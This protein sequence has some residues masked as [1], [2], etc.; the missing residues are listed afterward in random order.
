MKLLNL[1]FFILAINASSTYILAQQ[2]LIPYRTDEGK[3]G[4]K[5]LKDEIIVPAIYEE[6][7]PFSEGIGI[8]V[9]LNGYEKY[10]TLYFFNM[11]GKLIKIKYPFTVRCP[12]YDCDHCDYP[13]MKEGIFS[14]GLLP[15]GVPGDIKDSYSNAKWGFMNKEGDLIIKPE[16]DATN[17]FSDGLAPVSIKINKNEE[18]DF[19]VD[20]WF[21][22]F[23]NGKKKDIGEF[24]EAYR[25]SEGLALVSF[26]KNMQKKLGLKNSCAFIDKQGNVKIKGDFTIAFP[27]YEGLAA[28]A[29][30]DSDTIADFGDTIMK[31]GFIDKSGEWVIEPQFVMVL[32]FLNGVA[33]AGIG[34]VTEYIEGE[35]TSVFFTGRIVEI[36]KNGKILGTI[37]ESKGNEDDDDFDG[38]CI[39][40]I[41]EIKR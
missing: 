28:A 21:Y 38:C 13:N 19:G 7:Y 33:T 18:D 17:G 4:Y 5:N 22:I 26:K 31:W 41:D 6:T 11:K 35:I 8:A 24:N 25:F 14:N 2:E 12:I 16:F 40:L 9:G 36:D 3:A 27:F 20:N 1:F 30:P 29:I 23:T 34:K 39:D 37:K 10:D 15:V 32:P